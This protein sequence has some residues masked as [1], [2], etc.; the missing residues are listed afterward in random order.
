MSG[1]PFARIYYVDLQRDYPEVWR[2]NDVHATYSRLLALADATWPV[3][4]EVPRSEKRP[5]VQKLI[6]ASLVS[7]CSEF[8]YRIKGFDAERSARSNAASNAASIGWASRRASAGAMPT[9]V[10]SNSRP[11]PV[12]MP[13]DLIDPQKQTPEEYLAAVRAA[14]EHQTGV[15]L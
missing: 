9:P 14:Q 8:G 7:M 15:K 2:D 12:P 3:I 10:Q 4:P 6:D 5:Y 13:K 1:R 11:T